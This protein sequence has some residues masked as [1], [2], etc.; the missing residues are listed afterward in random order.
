MVAFSMARKQAEPDLPRRGQRFHDL[1]SL[2]AAARRQ[3]EAEWREFSGHPWTQDLAR[4]YDQSEGQ[5]ERV[6]AHE[7]FVATCRGLLDAVKA[8]RAIS[9]SQRRTITFLDELLDDHRWASI[10]AQLE[11][12]YGPLPLTRRQQFVAN[13]HIRAFLRYGHRATLREL[14][15]VSI[16]IGNFPENMLFPRGGVTVAQAIAAEERAVQHVRRRFPAIGDTIKKRGT[17][18]TR[19]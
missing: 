7:R 5:A 15:V 16:L 8:A 13:H 18:R 4:Y 10:S 11:T 12:T 9:D 14:A 3:C 1:E 19:G 6:A 2:R 17:R